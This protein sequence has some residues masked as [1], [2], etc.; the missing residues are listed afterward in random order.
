MGNIRIAK[1]PEINYTMKGFFS[2]ALAIL[3]LIFT[4]CNKSDRDLDDSTGSSISAW[5][6]MNHFHH[7]MREV[8]RVAQV[9]SVL[10]GI[11]PN[12]SLVPTNCMDSIRRTPDIGPFPIDLE[13]FYSESNNCA[14]QRNNSGK[15]NASF[16]GYYSSLGTEINVSL[17]NYVSHNVA[18]SGNI[19]MT[20]IKSVIDSLVFKVEIINGSLLDL[21]KPA[22]N[23]S[24]FA[25]NLF[26]NN[27]SGRK[28][29]PT[30]DDDFII[31]GT[32]NGMAENGVIYTYVVENE[33]V[34][35]A[36][37]DYEQFGSFRLAA[38][39]TQDRICNVNEGG[40]CDNIF[41]VAIPPAN[42][43]QIVEIK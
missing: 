25:A 27:Y 35:T 18:I 21:D 43:N 42:G 33:M 31:T 24:Y 4:S 41:Q 10:N 37:C 3:L 16:D 39:N 9:D 20:V 1:L 15:I 28:T 36:D 26:W 11:N 32:G 23:Q 2:A 34:F 17:E 40:G 22:K 6:S 29:G 7:I 14:D 8:H 12:D 13:I 5:T 30:N 19:K 38:P